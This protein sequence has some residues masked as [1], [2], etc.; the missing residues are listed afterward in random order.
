MQVLLKFVLFDFSKKAEVSPAGDEIDAIA[1]GLNTLAEEL[2]NAR[3]VEERHIALVNEK[4]QQLER[5]RASRHRLIE[6]FRVLRD[7]G[8]KAPPA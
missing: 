4:N 8:R 5:E 7:G 2:Q 1:M 3:E 6:E